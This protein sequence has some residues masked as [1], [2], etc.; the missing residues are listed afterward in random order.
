M[1]TVIGLVFT[2]AAQAETITV[3]IDKATFI[4]NVI[5]AR[6][7]DTIVW[8]NKDIVAH[9]ATARDKSWDL[10]VLSD[11]SQRTELKSAGDFEYFCRFHPNM[12][13]HIAV[14]K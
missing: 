6:V 9:T 10:M 7:G 12:V 8:R 13:G 3:T 14:T 11:K 2:G 5:S 1:A 4:P